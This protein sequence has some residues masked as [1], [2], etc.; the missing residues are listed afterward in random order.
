V[1]KLKATLAFTVLAVV[2][3]LVIGRYLLAVHAATQAERRSACTV[4]KGQ[5]FEAEAPDFTLPD[6]QGRQ[7]SLHELRGKVVLLNFWFT[8]CPPCVEEL[9][10]LIELGRRMAGRPFA[11]LTV[12]VDE[13]AEE[14]KSFLTKHRIAE[15]DLPILLDPGKKVAESYG[16]SKF[17]ETFLIDAQGVVRQKFIFK[18][19]WTEPASL[20]CIGTL[21]ER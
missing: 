6:L 14:V 13:T 20:S 15:R 9:P 21:L 18:R 19:N 3:I 1:S 8:G 16:T 10:S 2:A 11:L 17:P 5:P 12:S 4:L 7:R